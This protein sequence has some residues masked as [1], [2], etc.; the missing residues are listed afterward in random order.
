MITILAILITWYITKIYYTRSFSLDIEQSDLIRAVCSKCA[1]SGYISQDNLRVP[2]YCISCKQSTIGS[3]PY[4]PPPI[5]MSHIPL[6]RLILWSKV[7]HSGEFIL[8]ISR[9]LL[10]IYI[11]NYIYVIILHHM[12]RRNVKLDIL[13][14]QTLWHISGI[15]SMLS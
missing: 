1:R 4:I 6:R 8:Q 14:I 15:L 12:M 5:K 11:V 2:Y 13:D 9:Q 7:E 3:N 10:K